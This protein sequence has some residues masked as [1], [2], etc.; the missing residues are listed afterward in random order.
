MITC[1]TARSEGKHYY[2]S[3]SSLEYDLWTPHAGFMTLDLEKADVNILFH[4][5]M[6]KPTQLQTRSNFWR[7]M[8]LEVF[9]FTRQWWIQGG[10]RGSSPSPPQ[11]QSAYITCISR[12]CSEAMRWKFEPS[13]SPTPN[14]ALDPPLLQDSKI[15]VF[16]LKRQRSSKD[17]CRDSK[18]H[19][20]VKVFFFWWW[21][22][23]GSTP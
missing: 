5:K 17:N 2:D 10:S 14:E 13:S 12:G 6:L 18:A 21:R 16:D 4:P 9:N 22:S 19:K 1:R 11:F 15:Q 3:A 7:S 8:Q 20:S 23:S